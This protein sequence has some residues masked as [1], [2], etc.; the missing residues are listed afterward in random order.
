MALAVPATS[1]VVSCDTSSAPFNP[2]SPVA[3][4]DRVQQF[5]NSMHLKH[6]GVEKVSYDF[7]R[8]NSNQLIRVNMA[9]AYV[10]GGSTVVFANGCINMFGSIWNNC[11]PYNPQHWRGGV[12][13]SDD[14]K[15]KAMVTTSQIY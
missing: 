9:L 4:Y 1:E 3:L 14:Q 10:A 13:F 2:L 7:Y 15:W 6:L 5:C 12:S 11:K 8:P